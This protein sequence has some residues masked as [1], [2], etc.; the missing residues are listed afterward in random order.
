MQEW[1]FFNDKM[2]KNLPEGE[3]QAGMQRTGTQSNI[4][5]TGRKTTD[6]H[7]TA[8]TRTLNRETNEGNE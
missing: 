7:T 6:Q 4:T 3:K 8:D 2:Y 1:V 5:H